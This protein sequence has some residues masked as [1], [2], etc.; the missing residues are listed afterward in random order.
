M[1]PVSAVSMLDSRV[2]SP[3]CIAVSVPQPHVELHPLFSQRSRRADYLVLYP[4]LDKICERYGFGL[5]DAVAD[6]SYAPECMLLTLAR[7]ALPPTPVPYRKMPSA[8]H[9]DL[10]DDL[11]ARHRPLDGELRRLGILVQRLA[12]THAYPSVRALS[13]AFNHLRHNVQLHLLH[14][15]LVVFPLYLA[16]VAQARPRSAKSA[17]FTSALRFLSD[18]NRDIACQADGLSTQIDAAMASC[19]DP[20][21]DHVRTGVTALTASLSTNAAAEKAVLLPAVGLRRPRVRVVG[22]L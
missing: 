21:L 22:D 5:G 2:P 17:D 16:H 3:L 1:L 13:E 7:A 19:R 8:S 10:L 15:E 4:E 12:S 6:W 11:L 18:G 14:D 20:D 9:S